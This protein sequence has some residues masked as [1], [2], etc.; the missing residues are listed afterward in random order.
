MKEFVKTQKVT[1]NLMSFTGFKAL[2]IFSMLTEGPKSYEEIASAIENQPYLRERISIDTMRVY[3]NS[4]KRIGC[5]VKRIKGRDKISRYVITS[6][7]FELKFSKEQLQSA[8]K[9][10]KSLVKM[11]DVKDVIYMDKFFEK[12][13][14]YINDDNFINTVKGLS[15]LK[16]VNR[17]FLEEL[18]ICCENKNKIIIEYNSPNSGIKEIEIV[19]DK[20]E[21]LNNKI[22]LN[23]Y[24][25]EYGHTNNFLVSRIKRIKEVCSSEQKDLKAQKITY[26]LYTRKFEL[27]DYE[28]IIEQSNDKTL[29]EA[30]TSNIF[31]LRQRLL[32]YGPQCKII[33]PDSFKNEFVTLLNNMKAGYDD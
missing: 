17:E 13:G 27:A 23:G 25:F 7:P 28:K 5:D 3:I 31:F 29:I 9:V 6:H 8:V 18:I 33:A 21:I 12:I 16:D 19:A 2:L 4:L 26:E 24:G 1:Y 14:K 22:Y 30:E 20:I 15:M 11:M 10:Y 32:Q